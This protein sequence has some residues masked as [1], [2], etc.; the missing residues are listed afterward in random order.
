MRFRLWQLFCLMAIASI[1]VWSFTQF[2]MVTAEIDLVEVST[3]EPEV[4]SISDDSNR[5]MHVNKV[6]FQFTQPQDLSTAKISLFMAEPTKIDTRIKAGDRLKFRFRARQVLWLKPG[7][8]DQV[9]IHLIGLN[10]NQIEQIIHEVGLGK[11]R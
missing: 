7:R 8:P 3:W 6:V 5:P 4:D 1:A 9:A 10:P 2:G 11:E